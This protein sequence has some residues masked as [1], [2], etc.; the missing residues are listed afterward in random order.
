M[1]GC[2]LGFLELSG[3]KTRYN[4]T[5]AALFKTRA[6]HSKVD[7]DEVEVPALV[8]IT[9]REAS[10]SLNTSRK[11]SDDDESERKEEEGEQAGAVQEEKLLEVLL[12]VETKAGAYLSID[13]RCWP[14][15]AEAGGRPELD[16]ALTGKP[17]GC[18]FFTQVLLPLQAEADF[19]L[20][21]PLSSA[22]ALQQARER[23]ASALTFEQM[24]TQLA[25]DRKVHPHGLRTRLWA[26]LRTRHLS[27][28][29]HS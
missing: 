11:M 1:A 21:Q 29:T 17:L 28:L 18:C 26:C 22:A 19:L 25:A 7:E 14:R 23:V 6:D 24:L 2:N 12:S 8:M 5:R 9:H 4:E 27:T 13:R 3:A 20:R 16:L 10:V 15:L